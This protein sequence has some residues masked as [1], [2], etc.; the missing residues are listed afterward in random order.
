V[1]AQSA[2]KLT[3]MLAALNR[4]SAPEKLVALLGWRLHRLTGDR[5]GFWSLTV[6]GNWRLIFRFDRGDALDLDL[7]DYH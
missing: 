4:T 6:T 2:D 5:A 3:R 7:V 1:P